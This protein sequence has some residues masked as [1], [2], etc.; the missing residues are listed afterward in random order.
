[1]IGEFILSPFR[2]EKMGRNEGIVEGIQ[3][4]FVETGSAGGEALSESCADNDGRLADDDTG[5]ASVF[6]QQK[7]R[8]QAP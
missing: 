3:N 7:E 6:Q 8:E 2:N 5:C 1:M 4:G